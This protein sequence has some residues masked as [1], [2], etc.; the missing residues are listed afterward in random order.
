MVTCQRG[1]RPELCGEAIRMGRLLAELMPDEADA[2][3]L[4][5][6][7]LLHNSLRTARTNVL[8]ELLTLK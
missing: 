5:A 3:G 1:V 8:G 6:L 2:L 7:M 4:L